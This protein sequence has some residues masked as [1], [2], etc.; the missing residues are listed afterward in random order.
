MAHCKT[1]AKHSLHFLPS[2][3]KAKIL[4]GFLSAKIGTLFLLILILLLITCPS[5]CTQGRYSQASKNMPCHVYCLLGIFQT[6][7]PNIFKTWIINTYDFPNNYFF[8]KVGTI[9]HHS[10]QIKMLTLFRFKGY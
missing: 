8:H 9:L 5:H 7:I 10:L 6:Y 4:F 3:V 1:N 2:S